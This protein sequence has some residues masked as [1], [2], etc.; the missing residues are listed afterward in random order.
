MIAAALN[1]QRNDVLTSVRTFLQESRSKY[2]SGRIICQNRKEDCDAMVL[3]GIMKILEKKYLDDSPLGEF[4]KSSLEHIVSMLGVQRISRLCGGGGCGIWSR[5]NDVIEGIKTNTYGMNLP[6]FTTTPY[7]GPRWRLACSDIH[8]QDG[9][10]HV[11]GNS[12]FM[13]AAGGLY[14]LLDSDT[15]LA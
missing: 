13:N 6:D 1:S 12:F 5:W 9:A 4:H 11:E 10:D 8:T 3:G 14:Q 15:S 2:L 7:K